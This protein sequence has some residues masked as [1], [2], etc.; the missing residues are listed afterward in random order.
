MSPRNRLLAIVRRDPSFNRLRILSTPLSVRQ[1]PHQLEEVRLR[2]G[3]LPDEIDKLDAYIRVLD[4]PVDEPVESFF[5]RQ[6]ARQPRNR[7][8]RLQAPD[9]SIRYARF[10][11]LFRPLVTFGTAFRAPG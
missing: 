2:L 11:E 4:D 10:H 9:R 1:H 8:C 5:W 7:R 3:A 6:R